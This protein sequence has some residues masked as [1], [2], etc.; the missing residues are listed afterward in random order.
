MRIALFLAF[1]GLF[2][3]AASFAAAALALARHRRAARP[4]ARP[5]F[6]PP[7]SIVKA[8]SGLDDDLARNLESF[9]RLDY[10][11]YEILFSFARE[12]DP[13]FAIAR[14]V[15][16]AHPGVPTSFVVDPREPGLNAK[17]NRLAAGVRRARHRLLLL[18]DGNVRVRPDFLS[19]AVAPFGESRVGLVSN[20]FSAEGAAT[21]ASRIESLHLNGFLAAGT[22]LLARTLRRPCV[23]GKSI[24][25]SREAL[26]SIGG[27]ARLRDYL[28][29]DFLLGE[30][31]RAAGYEVRLSADEVVTAEISR[32]LSA[33]WSRHRR[34][35]ILRRRLGGPSYAAESFASPALWFCGVVGFSGGSPAAAAAGAL[36]WG[37]RL[38]VE[39]A[40]AADAGRRLRAGD[41]GLAVLRDLG[42]AALFWAGLFG[43]RTRWR[44]RSLDVGPGTLLRPADRVL[45]LTPVGEPARAAGYA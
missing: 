15:A 37:A 8:L 24:L 14:R 38:A 29:E 21:A 12:T 32:S 41:Y 6:E 28:A 45:A 33:V 25:M 7:V 13:A 5:G 10:P 22:A 27:F 17:V 35:A 18:A 34:W 36:I 43:R 23:V 40:L 3:S 19:R 20:L 30:L 16:D 31:V 4:E 2:A 42:V 9:Y 1:A 39:G 44:G 26:E 11:D